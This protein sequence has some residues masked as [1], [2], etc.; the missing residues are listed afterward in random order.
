MKYGE[1]FN[2]EALVE[3]SRKHL[4]VKTK[5]LKIFHLEDNCENKINIAAAVPHMKIDSK[6]SSMASL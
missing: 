6:G 3:E 5:D 1:K 2:I 4:N